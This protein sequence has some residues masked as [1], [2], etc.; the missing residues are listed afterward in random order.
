[1]DEAEAASAVH[2]KRDKPG[3]QASKKALSGPAAPTSLHVNIHPRGD[4][5]I[6]GRETRHIAGPERLREDLEA[7][8]FLISPTS[9]FQTNVRAARILVQ[10]VLAAVPADATV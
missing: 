2:T 10:L 7:A 3:R 8:S 9:F 4:A 5:F 1:P 6:F